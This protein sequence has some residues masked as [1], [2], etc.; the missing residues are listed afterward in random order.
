MFFDKLKIDSLIKLKENKEI[1]N[2]LDM[3]HAGEYVDGEFKLN[4][5]SALFF[6]KNPSKF[7]LF[8]NVKLVRFLDDKGVRLFKKLNLNTSFL[9]ILHEVEIFFHDTLPSYSKIN[10]FERQSI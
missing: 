10:G 5:A 1:T 7:N 9:K 4:N 6:A 2:V 3:I 8:Y